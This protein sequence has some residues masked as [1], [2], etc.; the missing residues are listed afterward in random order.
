MQ[1][2]EAKTQVELAQLQIITT[3]NQGMGKNLYL[4]I[5][6]AQLMGCP[7]GKKKNGF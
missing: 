5:R 6:K 2:Q 4:F 1:N 3:F 7:R